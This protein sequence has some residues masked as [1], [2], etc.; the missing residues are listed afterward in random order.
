MTNKFKALTLFS[1]TATAIIASIV[2]TKGSISHAS[3][4]DGQKYGDWTIK[5]ANISEENKSTQKCNAYT[6]LKIKKDDKDITIATVV[7]DYNSDSKKLVMNQ[8]LPQGLLLN[9]GTT[10]ISAKTT[11]AKANYLTCNKGY[12]LA[13]VQLSDEDINKISTE[14]KITVGV[15]NGEAKQMNFEFPNQGFQETVKA[16]KSN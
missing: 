12:C 15:F 16:I 3:A 1:L 8:Y 7:L 5:C 11:F 10:L 13:A 6:E 14:N 2:L 9:P 4:K